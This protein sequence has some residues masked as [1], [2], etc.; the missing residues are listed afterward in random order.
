MIFALNSMSHNILFN[1]TSL[2][3]LWFIALTTLLFTP[4]AFFYL[5]FLSRPFTNHSTAG[6]GGRHFFNSSLPLPPTSQTFRRQLGNYCRELD[7]A[8]RQQPDSNREPFV[9]KVKSLTTKLRAL[10]Y[11]HYYHLLNMNSS[12]V[13]IRQVLQSQYELFHLAFFR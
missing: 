6:E 9:S 13:S 4:F 12:L 3:S 10:F 11:A 7:S 1:K 8:H 5:G 2:Y